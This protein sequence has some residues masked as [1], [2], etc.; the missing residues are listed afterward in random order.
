MDHKVRVL[1]SETEFHFASDFGKQY[2]CMYVDGSPN[3]IFVD[4]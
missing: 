3:A 1:N 4:Q 2:V